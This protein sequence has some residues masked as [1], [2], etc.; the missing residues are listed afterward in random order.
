MLEK[1]NGC[2]KDYH[3]PVLASILTRSP[4]LESLSMTCNENR[5]QPDCSRKLKNKTTQFCKQREGFRN[6]IGHQLQETEIEVKGKG[7]QVGVVENLLKIAKG[8]KKMI[9]ISSKANLKSL[10]KTGYIIPG[11]HLYCSI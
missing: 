8:S 9:I 2:L 6:L 5:Y 11:Q 10:S 7:H 3:F 4:D 1:M